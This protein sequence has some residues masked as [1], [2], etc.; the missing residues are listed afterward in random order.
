MISNATITL[1]RKSNSN[2]VLP[3]VD[4]STENQDDTL[5]PLV[6]ISTKNTA[7][8][9][10]NSATNTVTVTQNGAV[11]SGY[12]F[13]T[14]EVYIKANDVTIKNSTF[15]GST[16]WYSV[17]QAAGYHGATIDSNTFHGGTAEKPLK[18]A[19]F[20]GSQDDITITENS[21]LNAPGDAVDIHGGT[22]SGNYFSGAGYSSIGAHPDAIWVT[23]TVCPTVISNNFVDWTWANGATSLSNGQDNDCVRI[24]TEQGSV[25][26]VTVTDNYLIGG[27][28]V[29]DAGNAGTK[30]TFSNISIKNNMIG[31]GKYF[32]I[33]PGPNSGV[34]Y[35]GNTIFDWSNSSYSSQ[36]WTA[37][38]AAGLATANLV[39]ASGAG[40]DIVANSGGSTTLYGNGT[41]EHLNGGANANVFVGGYGTQYFWG[42][43][44]KNIFTYLSIADSASLGGTDSIGNFDVTKDVLDLSHIDADLSQSGVQNFAFVGTAA[45]GGASGK[46]DYVQS[47]ATNQTFVELSLAGDTS[48]DMVIRLGGLL[49]LTA[50]DFALTAAQ[51]AAATAPAAHVSSLADSASAPVLNAD[52]VVKIKLNFSGAVKVVGG[53]PTLTL[54]DGGTAVYGG[55]SGTNVLTFSYTVAAKQTSSALAVTAVNLNGSTVRDTNGENAIL[56]GAVTTLPTAIRIDTTAPTVTSLFALAPKTNL[57][58]GKVVA[59]TAKLSEAVYV[60]GG[61]PTITLNDGGTAIYTGGSGTNALTFSYTVAAGQNTSVL[62]ATGVVLNGATIS[63]LAGNVAVLTGAMGVQSSS[64][65]IQIDTTAPTIKRVA[66]SPGSGHEITN[67]QSATVTLTTSEAVAVSGAPAL[68][69]NDGG[70]AIYQAAFSTSTDLVFR[71]TAGREISTGLTASGIALS[72]GSSIM[73]LA[74]N[75]ATLSNATAN[76]GLEVNTRTFAPTSI[77]SGNFTIS[78]TTEVE[79]FGASL[80]NLTF[81]NGSTGALKL[82]K[83]QYFTGTVAGL[84]RGDVIDLTDIGY[85]SA[86]LRYKENTLETGGDLIVS[87]GGH[88]ADIA[89][90]G[91]YNTSNF[92]MANDGYGGIKL[93]DLLANS[94]GSNQ[95]ALSHGQG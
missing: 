32:D 92:A 9:Y 94:S 30:G 83:S 46:V 39:V 95:L 69:L 6:S 64:A 35:S 62:K 88:A 34:T 3:S 75:L 31:F 1:L 14:A 84:N 11:L 85:S 53:S 20:I 59:L 10:Y 15:N 27:G 29:I 78:G 25:S 86:S 13:G 74:G 42:G 26:N 61:A 67:G 33:M 81:A 51:S 16:E 18:L 73:D 21:F 58:A 43:S 55:G 77:S 28:N 24:T 80:A 63:D 23:G 50:A 70:T 40:K 66:A 68:L 71:Y 49:N 41:V 36:A 7:P 5:L 8:F 60:A 54:N 44:G 87:N 89:L 79:M 12:D 65:L 48:P 2:A 91:M 47:A 76:T 45:L 19:A 90:I 93:T 37:Y 72:G 17:S 82:D 22:V 4:T 57:N 38:Q 52:K 56:A